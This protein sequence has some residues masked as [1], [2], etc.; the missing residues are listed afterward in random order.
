MSAKMVF[1]SKMPEAVGLL[2]REFWHQVCVTAWI[3]G[4]VTDSEREMMR[5]TAECLSIS[6]EEQVAIEGAAKGE[7]EDIAEEVER[8]HSAGED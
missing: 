3:D 2:H 5:S 1:W 7:A 8:E 6:R 4:V